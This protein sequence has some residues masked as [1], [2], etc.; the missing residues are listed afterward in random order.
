M[1]LEARTDAPD[2]SVVGATAFNRWTLSGLRGQK[3]VIPSHALDLVDDNCGCTAHT[4]DF[5]RL[6]SR[7][8]GSLVMLCSASWHIKSIRT[9][10]SWRST[11]ST[12]LC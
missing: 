2:F 9:G 1:K 10:P 12:S 5:R 8:E 6:P 7:V 3:I 11:H 4:C